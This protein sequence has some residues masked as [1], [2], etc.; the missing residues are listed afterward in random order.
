MPLCNKSKEARILLNSN[1]LERES[2][3]A[4][5][6]CTTC[7]ITVRMWEECCAIYSKIHIVLNVE[8]NIFIVIV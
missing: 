2:C 8:V 7:E 1:S 3:R 6:E 5:S 4:W